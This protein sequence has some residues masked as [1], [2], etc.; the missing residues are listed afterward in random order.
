MPD[1]M[2]SF[3][4]VR[5][6]CSVAPLAGQ[7]RTRGSPPEHHSDRPGGAGSQFR[8]VRTNRGSFGR[9]NRLRVLRPVISQGPERWRA[10]FQAGQIRHC[11]GP[12]LPGCGW[13]RPGI[14]EREHGMAPSGS[15]LRRLPWAGT[16][17]QACAA[18]P[19]ARVALALTPALHPRS[20]EQ[21]GAAQG[22]M[23]M[24]SISA[25]PSWRRA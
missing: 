18:S 9:D 19:D 8:D 24:W 2:H 13:P 4:T 3:P 7:A 10:R 1:H 22:I 11:H 21:A 23:A 16:A 25:P 6:P 17:A 12:V 15:W 5:I 14:R 20:P